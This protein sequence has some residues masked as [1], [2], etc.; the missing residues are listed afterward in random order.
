MHAFSSRQS[1]SPSDHLSYT[2]CLHTYRNSN[3]HPLS[4]AN[5]MHS[6]RYDSASSTHIPL[7]T[8]PELPEISFAPDVSAPVHTACIDDLYSLPFI[9]TTTAILERLVRHNSLQHLNIRYTIRTTPFSTHYHRKRFC[10]RVPQQAILR[11]TPS[12][13]LATAGVS[14]SLHPLSVYHFPLATDS[15]LLLCH[16][17]CR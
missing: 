10:H 13:Q 15:G 14:L 8:T 4:D 3:M 16:S 7:C 17:N 6:I 9:P 2:R 12:Y 5:R 11:T 1:V